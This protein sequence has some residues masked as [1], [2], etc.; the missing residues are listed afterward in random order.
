M[1]STAGSNQHGLRVKHH[2]LWME[3]SSVIFDVHSFT[4][5][6]IFL[7]FHRPTTRFVSVLN[8][9]ASDDGCNPAGNFTFIVHDWLES[10]DTAWVPITVN[11]LIQHRTGCVYVMDYSH[12]ANVAV[13]TNLSPNFKGIADVL[14]KKVTFIENYDR[15]YFFASGFGSRLSV[16]AGK[17]IGNQTID[18]MDLCD[19]TGRFCCFYIDR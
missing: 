11:S 14:T 6:L 19:P 16:E 4:E 5:I 12:F 7:C 3:Q 2:F 17:R 18:R 10:V 1:H 15:Q 13:Y 8:N 9:T